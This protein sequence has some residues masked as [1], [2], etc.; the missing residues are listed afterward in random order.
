VRDQELSG[1]LADRG[2]VWRPTELGMQLLI[3]HDHWLGAP[4]LAAWI[5]RHAWRPERPLG[6][7]SYLVPDAIYQFSLQLGRCHNVHTAACEEFVGSHKVRIRRCKNPRRPQVRRDG[8]RVRPKFP[9][10]LRSAC[11]RAGSGSC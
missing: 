9:P 6:G 4:Q 7:R 1:G 5:T 3:S 10:S 8:L 2:V 11:G